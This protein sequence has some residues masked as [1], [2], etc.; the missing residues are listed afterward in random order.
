[1]LA[2]KTKPFVDT[3][4]TALDINITNFELPKYLQYVP[5]D[6][7][8]TMPSGTLDAKLALSFTQYRD[9]SPAVLLRGMMAIKTLSVRELNM[10]PLF[11]LPRLAVDIDAVD[12]FSK[13]AK[14]KS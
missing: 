7:R 14:L 11:E 12:V 5:M 3:R 6:L 2:G 4:E 1:A 13:Q 8:F 9:K 10:A